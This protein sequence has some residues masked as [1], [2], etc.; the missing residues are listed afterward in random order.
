M[1]VG[2]IILIFLLFFYYFVPILLFFNKSTKK[3]IKS[4][5]LF[6]PVVIT[7]III[8]LIIIDNRKTAALY[9]KYPQMDKI[10]FENPIADVRD[11][12]IELQKIMD[13]LPKRLDQESVSYSLDKYHQRYNYFTYNWYNL[14]RFEDLEKDDSL[15]KYKVAPSDSNWTKY[16]GANF[17]PFSVLNQIEAHKFINLI[18][19]LDHNHLNTANIERNH[20][21]SLAYND[22]LRVN[23]P[24]NLG[25]R[26]IALSDTGYFSHDFYT[27]I[28]SITGVYLLDQK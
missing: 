12:I 17:Q 20:Q 25:F 19:Y 6:V 1:G 23:V 14:G 9:D 16:M 10:T 11:S 13:K 28:D 15:R 7:I 26:T 22:S 2:F 4:K 18:H 24:G 3:N 27:I 5:V 8:P 21:I